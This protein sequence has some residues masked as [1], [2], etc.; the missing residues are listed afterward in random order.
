MCPPSQ[1]EK[2]AY[3]AF[4]A[5]PLRSAIPAARKPGVTVNGHPLGARASPMVGTL[6]ADLRSSKRA[7]ARL[8]DISFVA[9]RERRDF[10]GLPRRHQ[11]KPDSLLVKMRLRLR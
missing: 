2:V 8:S 11:R 10:R 5:W 6:R 3:G 7:P 9:A 4:C 1:Q